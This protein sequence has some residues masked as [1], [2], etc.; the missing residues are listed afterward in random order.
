LWKGGFFLLKAVIFDLDN[1]LMDFMKMKEVAIEGAIEGM[2]DAGLTLNKEEARDKI[3]A[4]YDREGIEDQKVFDKFLL[5]EF[6]RID[7][8]IH[9]AGIV[10]YRR[11]KEAAMVLYPHVKMTLVEL[12]KRGLKLAVISDAPREQAWLRLCYLG[13]HHLFHPVITYEDTYR[14]KPDPEPFKTVLSRL[15]I[16][17]VEALM[18]GDWPER[19][20]AGAKKLGI[21][22]VFARYGNTFG[23]TG[24]GADYEIDDIME[25]LD[26]VDSLNQKER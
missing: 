2:I 13:L 1:T 22:T 10:G 12:I 8:K 24:S 11:A 23:S 3:K 7:Y 25:L 21:K 9:A 16:L 18:V 17:P 26:I 14:R 19:D 4:I 5:E 20:V 15:G 6:G